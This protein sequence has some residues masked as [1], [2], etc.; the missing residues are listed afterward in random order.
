MRLLRVI[1]KLNQLII[2]IKKMKKI[3]L[4]LMV[5][6]LSLTLIPVQSSAATIAK[7]STSVPAKPAEAAE[8]KTLE[9]RL[10]EINAMNKSELKSS[11]KKSLR[12]EVKSINR[13]MRE[14][15]GGVYLSV[16]AVIII[17]LLLVI[18]L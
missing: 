8:A 12:K 11:E 13:R 15:S 4:C 7:P 17:V 16:G 14:I 2:K 1:I 10:N 3:I 5:T 18:L 6:G 9:L